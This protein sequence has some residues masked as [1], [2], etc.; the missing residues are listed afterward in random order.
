MKRGLFL[1]LRTA[2]S[3]LTGS[4]ALVIGSSSCGDSPTQPPPPP[5]APAISLSK[6]SVSLTQ[7]VGSSASSESFDVSNSGGGTLSWSVAA[8]RSWVSA[9]P[10]SGSLSAGS[11]T[12]VSVT[13]SGAILGTGTYQ[14]G[15][16]VSGN[17]GNSPQA[18]SAALTVTQG[19][20][21]AIA[22]GT[23]VSG[24]GGEASSEILF[25]HDLTGG[26][27]SVSPADGAGALGSAR[28]D[29]ERQ[30]GASSTSAAVSQAVVASLLRVTLGGGSG[31]ADL[32]VRQGSP[33]TTATFDC[34]STESGNDENCELLNPAGGSWFVLVRGAGSF[35]GVTTSLQFLD[36]VEPASI[37]LSP[38]SLT[39]EAPEGSNASEVLSITNPGDLTLAWTANADEAWIGL[40]PASG[41]LAPGASVEV[42]VSIASSDLAT[43]AYSGAITV[44]D[45]TGS[46]DP[47][48]ATID[49]TV[50]PA[51]VIQLGQPV[52]NFDVL[53]GSNPNSQTFT[54]TNSGGLTLNWTA[55]EQRTW[56]ELQP[57]F[58]SLAPGASVDVTVSV[59]SA[60]LGA[61]T[62]TGN[63]TVEDANASNSPQTVAVNLTVAPVPTIQLDPGALDFTTDEGL[64]PADQTFDVRNTGE[65]ELNWSASA[66]Q[67]WISLDPVSGSVA[68]GGA[69][70]V[71]ASISTGSLTAGT[72]TGEITVSDPNASNSPQIMSVSL[73]IIPAG[74]RQLKVTGGGS[75]AGNVTSSPSGIDCD[76]SGEQSAGTCSGF[77]EQ[78]SDVTLTAT[79][80]LGNEFTEWLGDCS[81]SGDCVVTL[82]Q[83][84]IAT[85]RF[86]DPVM[87]IDIRF[88]AGSSPTESQ[89]QA[90]ADAEE[91]WEQ[92]I[93]LG[94]PDIPLDL[95]AGQCGS[96]APAIDETVDDLVI[97]ATVTNID[98][99]GGILGQAGPCFLRSDSRL[100]IL[101][102]MRFD[103]N[104]L[105]ALEFDGSDKL[106]DV[107]IHEMGH[108]LGIGVIWDDKGLLQQ[109]SQGGGLDPHFTG[110][111]AIASFDALGGTIYSG[112][113]VPVENF[114]GAG[115]A[116]SHWRESVLDAEL[117]TGFIDQPPN[118]LSRLTISSLADVG[119]DVNVARADPYF[120]VLNIRASK[121]TPPIQLKDDIWRGQ[122][123]VAEPDGTVR[124]LEDARLEND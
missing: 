74:F 23:P 121:A 70:T 111:E 76:L 45:P 78:D 9:T 8:D 72:Y 108:V 92:I 52:L 28:Q 29:E 96:N 83:N 4:V 2:A 58:G 61:N 14:A 86:E 15:I 49:L 55:T 42:T 115:T 88:T 20:P 38:A 65:A 36:D 122:I 21:L 44:S 30:G 68:V 120:I 53:E 46:A 33:P 26:S 37:Q 75:G 110:P 99:P 82:D 90:F 43:G 114:G 66:D 35:D 81:G 54:I 87:D 47:Q 62:Y 56:L 104:D 106:R 98:G 107:I 71:T 73:A 89:A 69:E 51:A 124:R 109:P 31:N 27:G 32:Y 57:V 19:S 97:L 17:A 94:I 67:S 85:A 22:D 11:S 39:V 95:P 59:L 7:E 84:R 112:K 24:L 93:T 113:K 18:I 118:P 48:S 105:E 64:D 103:S 6:S 25:Q 123:Y 50:A 101:G 41:S 100:P 13:T 40:S 16:A 80:E 63:I 10:A 3:V 1:N 60:G 91:R 77:F 5:P 117:M 34:A 79:S 119:Y 102:L 116:D 12:T